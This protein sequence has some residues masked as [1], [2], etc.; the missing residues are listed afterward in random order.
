MIMTG[1][2]E[3]IDLDPPAETSPEQED[4]LIVKVEEEDC[5]WMREYNP[6]VFETF[7]QRF[8]HFQYHEA[9][10]PREALSQLRVLC[11]EWLRPELHTKEQILELLVLEQ[12]LTILP[13]EFQTWVREHHPENGEEAVAVVE[14][15]E[16]EL[17]ERRQ[18]VVACAEVLPPKVVPPGAGPESFSHQLLPVDPQPER[19]PQRPHLREENALPALQVPSLPL[20]DSQELTASLLSAGSQKLVKI[21]DVA[22]VAVSFILEEWGHLDHSQKSLY[23]DDRKENYGSITSMDYESRNDN[24]E[25]MVKQIS[26]EAES[27]WMT[28]GS[29]ERNVPPSQEFGGVSDPHSVVERWQVNPPMGK[30]RQTPS[31]KRDLGAITD[32]N[33]KPNTNGER[34]HRCNDCGKFFLQASNFIQHRRIHTGEK[35]FKCGECGKSYNQRVHLTQ[36]QRVHTGEKPYKCQVCGKAFRVSSHLVQHHSVH[37]GERPY[38]C[39]ECG[40]SFG[41]H[42]HLIEHLKRHFRE[43]SQRC[44]DKRSKNTKLNVKKK[45]SEFSEADMEPTG[46][47]PRNVSQVQEFGEGHKHQ[48]K[49]DRKQ[50]IPMKEILGQPSSKRM[51]FSEVTYVHKKS[52]TGERPHKCNECGKSF[53]QSAHLIQHQ[54]IH[55]G[56]KP[57]RCDECGK[58][59]NQRVHLT[60]HQRVH[61][62]EKP[63]TCPLCGKAF[64]VRSHLVQHQSV[65]SGERPFKCNECGK[66]FG[67]RSHL[68]GHLRLHSREKSHQCHECG[69]IF[70]QYVSLIEHQVLHMGQ[71]NEQNSIRGEAY[72]WNLTVI[73][74]K[75]VELQEQPYKC[76]VCG[77]AFH[78]SSELIQHY[79]THT[80]EKTYKWD[81]CRESV[82]QCSHTKQHPKSYSNLKAHQCKECGRGFALKAHLNQHQRI[83]TGEKPFQCKECGMSFSWSC[84]LFKHL[85]SHERT[86]PIN[87]LSV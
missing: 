77:K 84:S 13:E 78:Y 67:R 31:Q 43:K 72:S 81:M 54:R 45:I 63:Y 46:I 73:E 23:R 8:K 24:V 42:S 40:K 60:Q 30:S 48:G 82:G 64:R 5:T 76:D 87:T 4:L 62:G 15:I 12:F 55:T 2:G 3:V 25:L 17:E 38:G 56:E 37:S 9:S 66:G 1:S 19:E 28:S 50:G 44:N 51:N 49:L 10:G 53:I 59:Y 7:Y 58:S 41:R 57:F 34:G 27:P 11:C 80:A 26:D 29:P 65:H 35:P 85:R 36:H 52:S 83:H 6:P 86:D 32:V 74:D 21:E 68:A 39:P 33:R 47:I 69:E 22:D 18:Q 70:F 16:R 75:K 20:K 79:R 61:T 71:K 14:N